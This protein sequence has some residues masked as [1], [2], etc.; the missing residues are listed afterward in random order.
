MEEDG[1]RESKERGVGWGSSSQLAVVPTCNL[2]QLDNVLS[3]GQLYKTPP[4]WSVRCYG[5]AG[6]ALAPAAGPAAMP[7]SGPL[8]TL[9]CS[10][11]STALILSIPLLHPLSTT[12]THIRLI[13]KFT[14]AVFRDGNIHFLGCVHSQTCNHVLVIGRYS[15]RTIYLVAMEVQ[16]SRS[17]CLH[18]VL[19]Y[20]FRKYHTALNIF[21]YGQIIF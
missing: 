8:H 3:L 18:C 6:W 15:S 17:G 11:Q 7:S 10:Q 19:L 9:P 14:P 1:K 2:D 16:K 4:S 21:T 12:V 5:R 20:V 13:H